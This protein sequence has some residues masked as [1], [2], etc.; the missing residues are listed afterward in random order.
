MS[1]LKRVFAVMISLSGVNSSFAYQQIEL[2]WFPSAGQAGISA[3][4]VDFDDNVYNVNVDLRT[5]GTFYSNY[6]KYRC[7]SPSARFDEGSIDRVVF[8]AYPKK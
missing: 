8:F 5:N 2:L 3:F 7:S 1:N 6:K 4:N